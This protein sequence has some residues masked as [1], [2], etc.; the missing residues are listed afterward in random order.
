MAIAKV[1]LKAENNIKSGVDSAK[2]D[3]GGFEDA[4][5]KLGTALKGAFAITAVL[6]SLKQ[7]GSF[8]A[9]CFNEF[10]AGERRLNQL[11]IALDNNSASF[12]KATT[13]IDEMKR[14]SMAS[15]DDIE[16]LVA[17]LAAL[18]KSDEEIDKITRAS[19]NLSNITGKGLKESF[20]QINSTYSGSV[21]ELGK[22]IPELKDLTKEQLASGEA[23]NILNGKFGEMSKQLSENSFAQKIKNIKDDFGDMKQ[24]LGGVVAI[25]FAPLIDNFSVVIGNF[26]EGV[27]TFAQRF[28]A[29]LENFPEVARLSFGLILD[30]VETTFSWNSLKTIFLSLGEYI[31]RTFATVLTA[32]PGLWWDVIKLM[33]NPVKSLGEYMA[34]TLGKAV[35]LDFKDIMSPGEFIKG[36]LQEEA[37]LA[38]NLVSGVVNLV[39]AQVNNVK[40]LGSDLSDIYKDIDWSGFKAEVDKVLAPSLEKYVKAQPLALQPVAASVTAQPQ[41]GTTPAAPSTPEDG[42]GDKGKIPPPPPTFFEQLKSSFQNGLIDPIKSGLTNDDLFGSLKGAFGD[43]TSAIKPLT[44]IIFSSNPLFA[45]LMPIIE[46][47]VKVLSPALNQVIQP[48]MAMLTM[49]GE[50]LGKAL[51]PILSAIAPIFQILANILAAAILPVIQLLTPFINLIAL[52]FQMLSPI[53]NLVAKAFTILMSPVQFLGDLFSW[54]GEWISTL[55]KNI[56]IAIY[57]ITHPFKQKSYASGPGSFSSDAFSGLED[58]LA[59]MDGMSSSVATESSTTAMATQSASYTGASTIHINIYQQAPVVGSGGMAEFARMIRGEFDLIDYYNN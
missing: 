13:L 26:T 11:S 37:S 28:S 47:M 17:E 30:I 54:L 40:E 3:L 2:R 21:D 59:A 46:G 25:N 53:L 35:R 7:L 19:V 5:K 15:K 24:G 4:A 42:D 49:I 52:N 38:K 12:T 18:G 44:D 20:T 34:D 8:A 14:M 48:L 39:S 45:A 50:T 1:I 27:V 29:V 22:L 41:S 6:A 57:N 43:I 32:L 23:A 58:R 56:G 9:D 55:G 31:A 16:E 10:A 36:V 51:L 33:F